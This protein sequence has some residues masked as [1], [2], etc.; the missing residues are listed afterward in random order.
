MS[1]STL[2]RT[3]LLAGFGAVI[4][5]VAAPASAQ[6]SFGISNGE[7]K[8]LNFSVGGGGSRGGYPGRFDRRPHDHFSHND[9]RPAPAPSVEVIR[10][11]T[12]STVQMVDEVRTKTVTE[13][14]TQTRT[15]P[16]GQRYT[17]T[18]PVE[19]EVNYT[20]KVP[21]TVEKTV[22]AKERVRRHGGAMNT[23]TVN[24][25]PNGR[26]VTQRT[27]FADGSGISSISYRPW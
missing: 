26:E 16:W 5:C 20:V 27:D 13:M 23:T 21:V 14:V 7:G 22:Y 19:R 17:V 3:T 8:S 2:A 24:Y 10:P 15:T 6:F 12:I 25:G 18:I 9:W 11:K 1:R 4:L